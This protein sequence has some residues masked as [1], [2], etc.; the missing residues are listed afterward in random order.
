MANDDLCRT[1]NGHLKALPRHHLGRCLTD[2]MNTVKNDPDK[3]RVYLQY[4]KYLGYSVPLDDPSE[5]ADIFM[6]HTV[7]SYSQPFSAAFKCLND[8]QSNPFEE[9]AE[10]ILSKPRKR[11][12]K[13]T[14]IGKSTTRYSTSE[15]SKVQTLLSLKKGHEGFQS[16]FSEILIMAVECSRLVAQQ[17]QAKMGLSSDYKGGEL[18][19]REKWKM[20]QMIMNYNYC[21]L[22]QQMKDKQE[23]DVNGNSDNRNGNAGHSYDEFFGY[24]NTDKAALTSRVQPELNEE[25]MTKIGTR[26]IATYFSQINDLEEKVEEQKDILKQ[27]KEIRTEEDEERERKRKDRDGFTTRIMAHYSTKKRALENNKKLDDYFGKG[28]S[29]KRRKHH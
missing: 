20:Y 19:E 29:P 6:K 17:I 5:Y 4:F 15:L 24:F 16:V 25:I 13:K 10:A 7:K 26:N 1:R 28:P 2:A 18:N 11:G 9:S 14:D 22:L 27:Q 3:Q 8:L 23:Q 12:R 21:G